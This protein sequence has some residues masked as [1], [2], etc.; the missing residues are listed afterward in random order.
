MVDK[1]RPVGRPPKTRERRAQ[2]VAAFLASIGRVG[3]SKTSVRLVAQELGLDR[4]TVHHYFPSRDDLVV[5]AME[6]LIQVYRKQVDQL[7]EGP[8]TPNERA[9]R[10]LDYAFGE[11]FNEPGVSGVLWEFSL[12]SRD[13]PKAFAE[14]QR[15]YQAFED[16][17]LSELEKRYP[18]APA[19]E[20]RRVAFAVVQLSEGASS[21][22][23]LG[24][25]PDRAAAARETAQQ[26]VRELEHSRRS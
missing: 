15:A 3:L 7:L 20:I 18:D 2:I 13:D 9:E 10:L 4:T 23:D 8:L 11:D 19:D 24:F 12:A 1:S 25:G 21:F 6:H 22:R 5:A 16:T 26:L 14:L 17:A